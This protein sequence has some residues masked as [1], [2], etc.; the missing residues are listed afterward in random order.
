MLSIIPEP[1]TKA[2]KLKPRISP[3]NTGV[4]IA[5]KTVVTNAQ[6]D[7]LNTVTHLERP[8]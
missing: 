1:G 8:G 2:H 7:V 6:P 5:V 4:A 3:E